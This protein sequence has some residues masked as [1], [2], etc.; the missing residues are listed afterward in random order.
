MYVCMGGL[1]MEQVMAQK[2]SMNDCTGGHIFLLITDS[3][4]LIVFTDLP[5]L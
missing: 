4:V 2:K 3:A 1:L 5:K